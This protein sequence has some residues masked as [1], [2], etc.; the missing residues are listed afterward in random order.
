MM[1]EQDKLMLISKILTEQFNRTLESPI[2][3]TDKLV[4]FNLDSLDAVELQ[5]YL[6]DVLGK[7]LIETEK[8]IVTVAELIEIM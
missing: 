2:N 5:M 6:E 3:L 7:E 8:P 4:D 1:T